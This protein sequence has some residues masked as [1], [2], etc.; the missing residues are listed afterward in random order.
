MSKKKLC[1]FVDHRS[2]SPSCYLVRYFGSLLPEKLAAMLL[3]FKS[4]LHNVSPCEVGGERTEPIK[5]VINDERAK[6]RN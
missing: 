6:C 3:F 5:R 2:L 1:M 4:T